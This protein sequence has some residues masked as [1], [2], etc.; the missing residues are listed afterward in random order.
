[1]FKKLLMIVLL[2]APMTLF[3]QKYAHIDYQD[4]VTNLPAYKTAM[5]E[6]ETLGKQYDA[7]LKSM[8]QEGQ[9]KLEKYQKEVNESTPE[10]I[11]KR[12]EEELTAIQQRIEQA[13]QDNQKAFAEA[14][15][16]KM[17]P[18]MTRVNDAIT[19]VQKE[20][21]YLYIMDKAMATQAGIFINDAMSTD[22]TA[23][24]KSKLGI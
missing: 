1:M 19:A 8:Q 12:M 17:Q 7:D 3:A 20:G 24:V 23:Q 15:Q 6:L 18:I 2:A 11:R 21:G 16:Q 4:I 9:T 5:T 13:Y 22:V 10:N 14:Q